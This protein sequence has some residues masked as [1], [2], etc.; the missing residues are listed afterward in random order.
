LKSGGNCIEAVGKARHSQAWLIYHVVQPSQADISLKALLRYIV[1]FFDCAEQGGS[2]LGE[3]RGGRRGSRR[4]SLG[5]VGSYLRFC[6]T[7]ECEALMRR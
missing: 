7:S 6:A 2:E 1:F 5:I 3:T 4:G